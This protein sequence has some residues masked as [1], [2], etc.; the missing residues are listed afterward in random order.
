MRVVKIINVIDGSPNIFIKFI[1]RP[2]TFFV[3]QSKLVEEKVKVD[4]KYTRYG[5]PPGAYDNFTVVAVGG[6]V[7]DYF[8]SLVEIDVVG[9]AMLKEGDSMV[10]QDY[11]PTGYIVE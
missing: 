5:G 6:E 9:T 1:G 11:D 7:P 2:G 4:S 10:L 8:E 3:S